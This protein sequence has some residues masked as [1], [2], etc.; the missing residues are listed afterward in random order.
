MLATSQRVAIFFGRIR[1][2]LRRD[3]GLPM[4]KNFD[5][6]FELGFTSILY[7]EKMEVSIIKNH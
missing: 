1:L 7:Q 5:F 2:F 4:K 6:P 3:F